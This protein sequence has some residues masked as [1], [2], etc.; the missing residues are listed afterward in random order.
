MSKKIAEIISLVLNPLVL[1]MP[2]PFFLVFEKTDNLARSL[3]WTGISTFF[4]FLYFLLIVVGIKFK[5][6]SDLDISKREQRPILFLVGL[7]LAISYLVVLFLF[8]APGILQI[9]TFALILGLF[10]IGAVNMFTK[11]SGHLAVLS[12]FLTFA[13]LVEGWIFLGG[14]VLL[15]VLAWARI[16]TKNHTLSQTVLGSVIGILTTV[17]IY[18]IVKYIVR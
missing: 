15:P 12:A 11:V 6:F 16:K 13:V 8:H 7:F 14:F 18:V 1:L 17:I 10:V 9:G 3:A 5:I 4:I 2:I